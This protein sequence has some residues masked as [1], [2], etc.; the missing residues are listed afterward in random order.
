MQPDL[1][2]IVEQAVHEYDVAQ[3][4]AVDL[5][6]DRGGAFAVAD[7]DEPE[8]VLAQLSA[9]R[10]P[11]LEQDIDAFL[12]KLNAA[13]PGANSSSTIGAGGARRARAER[14]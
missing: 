6:L 1:G 9:D 7:E 11:R 4:D 10:A 8:L 12:R 13:V 14:V 5:A 3:S 2:G